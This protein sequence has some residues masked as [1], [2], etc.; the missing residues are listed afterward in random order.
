[1]SIIWGPYHKDLSIRSS[2][3]RK[4]IFLT[5]KAFWTSISRLLN[6]QNIWKSECFAYRESA[7]IVM[8][9]CLLTTPKFQDTHVFHFNSDI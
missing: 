4:K 9:K 2:N 5:S 7:V 8:E 6:M 3:T 1:M